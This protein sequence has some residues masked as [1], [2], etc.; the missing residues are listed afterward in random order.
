[1]KINKDLQRS[2]GR[3][4]HAVDDPPLQGVT[5]QA[6]RQTVYGAKLYKKSTP[7]YRSCRSTLFLI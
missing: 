1:M 4:K 5:F 3:P 6:A 7:G 2:P